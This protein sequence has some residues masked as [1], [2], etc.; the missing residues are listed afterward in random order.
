MRL[1]H[2]EQKRYP[3]VSVRIHWKLLIF[4]SWLGALAGTSGC[5]GG[6]K[7]ATDP[8]KIIGKDLDQGGV[9][10]S[11]TSSPKPDPQAVPNARKAPPP[12]VAATRD[13]CE[14][15]SRHVEELGIDLAINAETDP[16]K[17]K[18]MADTKAS[19]MASPEMQQR[20][21][22]GTDQCLQRGT[23]RREARCIAQIRSEQDI[24]RCVH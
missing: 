24:D 5:V 15:A 16:E 11:G 8:Q 19:T 20:I 14:R 17:K 13:D 1:A 3:W 18:Q 21:R 2:P 6:P 12:E 22:R 7:E 9:E 4:A 10:S 23:S